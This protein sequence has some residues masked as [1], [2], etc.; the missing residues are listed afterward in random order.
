MAS[1]RDARRRA[2]VDKAAAEVDSLVGRGALMGGNA[3]S[4]VLVVKG[5]PS[6]AE[7]DGAEPLSGRDGTALRASLERLGYP[8][9]DWAWLAV[10][11]FPGATP[12]ALVREAVCVLDPDTLVCADE[13]A[14]AA[15][16]DAFADELVDVESLEEAMLLPDHVA[17]VAGMRVT[18]L[19]GFEAALDDPEA[20]RTMWHRI[21]VLRPLA[22]PY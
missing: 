19:G 1:E 9:E 6:D 20:K 13:A 15:V 11:S 12:D 2:C 17:H 7:R 16:R 10:G 14:A 22:E 21:Q 4:S 3:F 5:D 8:P 18:N